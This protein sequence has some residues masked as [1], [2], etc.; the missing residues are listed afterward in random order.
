MDK[1]AQRL[2]KDAQALDAPISA[3]LENRIE[4]TLRASEPHRP[5]RAVAS[6]RPALFWWASSL[7]GVAA[8]AIVL[9]IV[10][11]LQ[12]DRHPVP[13]SVAST[14]LHDAT[15]GAGRPVVPLNVES[16]VLTAPLQQEL[17]DLQADLKKAQQQV[18]RD[19]GL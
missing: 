19:I 10:N 8:A 4:A 18:R 5:D 7:T 12:P 15:T 14:A 3:E 16:A 9:V 11:V 13:P 17:V 6:R 1:L 2:K